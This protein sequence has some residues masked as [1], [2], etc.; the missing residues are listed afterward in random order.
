MRADFFC[1]DC[2][3]AFQ[4]C[5]DDAPQYNDASWLL[6]VRWSDMHASCGWINPA[7][8]ADDPP[9]KMRLGPMDLPPQDGTETVG[10]EIID[11]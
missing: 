6:L 7:V 2:G 4:I 9:E 10:P 3:G 5:T 8:Q 11:G 1:A